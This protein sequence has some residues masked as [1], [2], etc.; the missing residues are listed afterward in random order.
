MATSGNFLTSDSGQGGGNFYG[1]MI[2]EWWQTGAGISGSVGYHNI[3]YHLKTYGGSSAYYQYF[4]N[5][6][7]NVDGV[8]YSWGTTKAYGAGATSFG[9]YANTLYTDSNGNRSFGASAQGGIYNNTI[10]TS[11]SGSWWLDNIPLYGGIDSWSS[12]SITDED[13]LTVNWHK[14]TGIP[15][16]WLRLDNID[17]ADST[18]HVWNMG[19]PY[20]FSNISAWAQ[21]KMVNVSATTMYLYYGDD[22]NA[23]GGVDHWNA[24]W[25]GTLYIKNDTGQANPTF[26]N[27][28]FKDNNPTTVAITGNDQYLIQ[29]YSDLL[30]TVPV[31]NKATPNKGAYMT[32]YR[33]YIGGYNSSFAYSASADATKS[34]GIISDITGAR[35]ISVTAFDSRLNTTTVSKTINILPYTPPVVNSTAIRANG[36]DD[37]L[38]LTA[39]GSVSPL[40][41]TGTDKNI[42]N[43]TSGLQYRVAQ[44]GA[45]INAQSW[46]NI[47]STQTAGTGVITGN[48]AVTL[49]ATGAASSTHSFRVQV[50]ITDKLGNSTIQTI[51]ITSGIPIFRIGVDNNIYH[52]EVPMYLSATTTTAASPA[53]NG[54]AYSNKYTI[55]A[56][57]SAAAFANPSGNPVDGNKLLIR[58][59][60]NGTARAITWGSAYMNSGGA[61]MISTTSVNKTHLLGFI[62]DSAVSK[63]VCVAVDTSGY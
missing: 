5:G 59:K 28:T 17:N 9:D 40:T 23:D 62:Y 7:M 53:P 48:A 46:V 44:D 12:G 24:A 33:T 11:G 57:A 45:D 14:N 63:W 42:I 50:R 20:T 16:L 54:A 43:A 18:Y 29:G 10:N 37:A 36:Y 1:R 41:I 30:L 15:H 4:F 32:D 51:D 13:S 60:D 31:A 6:S 38:I 34:I 26:S 39:G 49:A 25:Q 19:N 3:S 8:G 22:L 47:P 2:F 52:K 56:Q 55:T 21:S 35:A 61:T 58:I 27:F